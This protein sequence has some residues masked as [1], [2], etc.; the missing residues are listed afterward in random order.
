MANS[1]EVRVPILDHEYVE[2]IARIPVEKKLV[3]AEGKVCFKDALSPFLPREILY[4]EKMGFGVPLADWFRGPLHSD[5]AA[6]INEGSI[7]RSGIFD[8]NALREI[9]A[10]HQ[11]GSRDHSAALWA[12]LM[13]SGSYDGLFG[14]TK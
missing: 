10:Q 7:A 1:L 3:G 2:W 13:F 11:S 12:V 8:V 5:V 6:A 14:P 9:L 4:R